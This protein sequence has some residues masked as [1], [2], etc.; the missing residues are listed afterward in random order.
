MSL[1]D[2]NIKKKKKVVPRTSEQPGRTYLIL[3]QTGL[4]KMLSRKKWRD[5]RGIYAKACFEPARLFRARVV[6][7]KVISWRW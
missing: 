4:F 3:F 5:I 2:S 7:S 1:R 6:A